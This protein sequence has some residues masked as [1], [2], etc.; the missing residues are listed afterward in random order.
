MLL[1]SP[2]STASTKGEEYIGDEVEQSVDEHVE[3]QRQTAGIVSDKGKMVAKREVVAD[4]DD[5][6]DNIPWETTFVK[7]MVK[8]EFTS[9]QH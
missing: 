1:L 4:D 7:T 9:I 3:K 5:K 6:V 8:H 2:K